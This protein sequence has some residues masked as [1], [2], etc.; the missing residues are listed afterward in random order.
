MSFDRYL[1]E[2]LRLHVSITP[3]DIVKL[4]YQA[5]FGPVHILK[6]PGAAKAMLEKEI[7][8]TP[9]A[10]APLYEFISDSYVRINLAAWKK[11]RLPIQWLSEMFISSA[12]QSASAISEFENLLDR[13]GTV[14]TKFGFSKEEWS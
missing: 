7:G 12:V 2:Q 4:C 8:E 6:E 13:A 9:V 5:A 3:L 14:L 11:N 10:D 1:R